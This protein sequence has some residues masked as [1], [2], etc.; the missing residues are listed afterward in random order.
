MYYTY[1][2]KSSK[3]GKFYYGFTHNVEARL[4]EHNKGL[5]AATKPYIPWTLVWYC[6]FVKEKDA[7]DFELYL[8]TGS[9]KAFVYKRLARSLKEG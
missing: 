6:A 2:L 9:G 8:K 3:S 1:I 5:S 7:K 4:T